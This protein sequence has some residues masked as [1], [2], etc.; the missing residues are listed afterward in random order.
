MVPKTARQKQIVQLS[1]KLP[2]ITEK[3]TQHAFE[4]SFGMY[5]CRSR[6]TLFCLECGHSW[7]EQSSLST[8][9][10]GCTCPECGKDLK[11][12]ENYIK[13]YKDV[14]YYGILTTKG[15]FQVVRMFYVTKFM[16]KLRKP[17]FYIHE[18]IQH[19]IE[20]TGKDTV[21][22][23]S[24]QGLSKYYD[25]WVLQSELEV[26]PGSFK[27]CP[28]YN[29]EP[30]K[31]YPERR[32]LPE[33]KRNGFKGNFHDLSPHHFFSLILQDSKAET[34]LKAGQISLFKQLAKYT[35]PI[36]HHWNT[37]KICIRNGYV[38]KDGQM[39]LDHI[40]LLDH[41]GKDLRSPKYVCPDN[42]L[43]D[44]NRLV[45]KKREQDKKKRLKELR[46]QIAKDQ[47]EYAKQKA[48]FFGL[49]FMDGEIHIKTLESVE[50]VMMEGDELGHCVFE[51]KYHKKAGSL[52]MSA[53]IQDKPIETIEIN[54]RSFKIEQARGKD[55]K[56]T[57]YH[58]RIVN[59]V[60]QN[61]NQIH[62]LANA[63]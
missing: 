40:N 53:R 8:S 27:S 19:W 16:K 38:V 4:K 23:K 46:E 12:K 36:W 60:N 29:L 58:K 37:I 13:A 11:L 3:Q 31:I 39:W 25:Q 34:L 10:T 51:N 35:N 61:M 44:H 43:Q 54:L 7:K 5:V 14:E 28:R 49:Q 48:K 62:K 26:R 20:T 22:S 24:V 55:N 6:K 32:I 15:G 18:V 42:L 47:V 50:E 59:L 33:I 9:L 57:K 30:Y 41:F 63:I 2:A 56:A 21:M 52:I 17:E 1:A 45:Q